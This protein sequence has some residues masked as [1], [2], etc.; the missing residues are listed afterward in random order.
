MSIEKMRVSNR[1]IRII[2]PGAFLHSYQS[3]LDGKSNFAELSGQ[4]F[5]IEGF[6]TK[7]LDGF[8]FP[9]NFP[10]CCEWHRSTYQVA[11]DSFNNF[12][13]CCDIHKKLLA[14]PWFDKLNYISTPQKV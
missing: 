6:E 5:L 4:D 7:P 13:N 1:T 14:A 11:L 3:Y 12:P 10:E 8:E 2:N 9:L